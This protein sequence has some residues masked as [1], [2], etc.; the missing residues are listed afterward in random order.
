[1]SMP[2]TEQPLPTAW[3]DELAGLD[4]AWQGGDHTTAA[5]VEAALALWRERMQRPA[6]PDE[7]WFDVVDASGEP[8]GWGAPRWFCHLTGLRHRV[9]HVLLTSPQ[10]LMV[11]QMRAH[12]KAE[13]PSRIDTTVGGHLKAGQEWETGV[14]AEIEEEIGLSAEAVE[15]WLVAGKLIPVGERYHRYG[16]DAGMPPYRNRQVN[17]LYGGELTA[18]GLAH[19]RFSDGEVSG[20][21]LCAPAEVERMIQANFLIAPGLRNA[22]PRW[23]RWRREH[24]GS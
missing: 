19:L 11:L 17:Q 1:M 15:Q 13:W 3:L 10:G 16:V 2:P 4:A 22:F 24:K 14:L 20:M 9:V 18:W 7:E 6:T 23:Q 12:D 8:F 21:Y 5:E